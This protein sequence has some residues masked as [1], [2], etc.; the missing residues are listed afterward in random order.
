MFKVVTFYKFIPLPDLETKSDS[1]RAAMRAFSIK[2]TIVLADEGFNS[3]ISGDEKNIQYFLIDAEKI[4]GCG[5]DYKSSFH[6]ETPFR[7]IDVKIKPEIVTLK[8]EVDVS[9]GDGTHVEASEWNALIS[10]P[11]ILVLDARNDYEVMN[12]SFPSAVNP[13]TEKFSELPDYVAENLDP[14]KHKQIAMYCTGGIRC[15]KFAPYLK[16]KGFE[17]VYQLKGGILK[18]L[19][20]IDPAESLWQ[21]ECFVFDDRRTVD[22]KLEKGVQEDYSQAK[23]RNGGAK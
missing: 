11:E 2:G 8:R 20:D 22:H 12:G 14:A 16:A 10:D 19:E 5:I 7:K 15:E 23:N 4:L 3:T 9:L 21:G 6:S 13:H 1:L 18:Y 17:N